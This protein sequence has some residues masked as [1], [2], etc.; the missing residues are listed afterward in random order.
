MSLRWPGGPALLK[1]ALS[2]TTEKLPETV[3]TLASGGRIGSQK[4]ALVKACVC[5][6]ETTVIKVRVMPTP[7]EWDL[8]RLAASFIVA[9]RDN[10][11]SDSTAKNV[12]ITCVRTYRE[13]MTEFSKMKT[14]GLWY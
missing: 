2:K 12:V 11:L 14:L 4:K 5:A 10:G 6:L 13:S 9:C 3:A 8:K 1:W 7:W